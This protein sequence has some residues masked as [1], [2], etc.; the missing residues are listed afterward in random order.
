M[1]NAFNN[2]LSNREADNNGTTQL[3]NFD[4]LQM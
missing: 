4:D 3:V 2:T 1:K